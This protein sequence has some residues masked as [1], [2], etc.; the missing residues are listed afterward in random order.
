MQRRL[1]RLPLHINDADFASALVESW[2]EIA[3]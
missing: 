2:R 1:I 3:P